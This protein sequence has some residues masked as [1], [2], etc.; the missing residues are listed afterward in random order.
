MKACRLLICSFMLLASNS[1]AHHS[2]V[3]EFDADNP[4]TIE[5]V[6]F[7]AGSRSYVTIGRIVGAASSREN[8][9]L[10]KGDTYS[11]CQ[12]KANPVID[13]S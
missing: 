12:C 10:R 4:I 1:F 2:Y 5:G 11:D 13:L 7:A 8:R 9:P 6:V 3:A